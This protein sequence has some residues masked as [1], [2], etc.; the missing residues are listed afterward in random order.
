MSAIAQKNNCKS[1]KGVRERRRNR[2]NCS[3][4]TVSEIKDKIKSNNADKINSTC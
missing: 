4:E 1:L 3:P 2:K